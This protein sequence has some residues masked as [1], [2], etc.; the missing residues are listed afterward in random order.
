MKNPSPAVRGSS[1][2]IETLKLHSLSL[3]IVLESLGSLES[4]GS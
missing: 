3:S 1:M 4:R 2:S